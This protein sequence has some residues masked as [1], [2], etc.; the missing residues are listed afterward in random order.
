MQ[1]PFRKSILFLGGL[2]TQR[3]KAK[4]KKT[5]KYIENNEKICKTGTKSQILV[6]NSYN[7]K[8]LMF[9]NYTWIKYSQYD[10]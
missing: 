6:K 5:M 7:K 8:C 2:I 10:T 4:I 9:Q 3:F 1:F